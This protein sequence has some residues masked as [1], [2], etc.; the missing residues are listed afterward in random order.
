MTSI[1]SFIH[2]AALFLI[3][4]QIYEMILY[5]VTINIDEDVQDEW[6]NWMKDTHIPDVMKTGLFLEN[7]ICRILAEEEGGH[8]YAI[9]YLLASKANYDDYQSNH[10]ANLQAEHN[11]KFNGKFA[12]FRTILEVIHQH[13]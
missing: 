4:T 11:D 10:A 13:P 2:Y 5:N 12:A 8:S 1:E 3:S 9:Q 6:L 7:R